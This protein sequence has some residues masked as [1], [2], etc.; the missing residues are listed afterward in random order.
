M[1][2]PHQR[3]LAATRNDV[4]A[5]NDIL[6]E[7]RKGAINSRFLRGPEK[8]RRPAGYSANFGMIPNFDANVSVLVQLPMEVLITICSDLEPIWVFQL[9]LTCTKMA[10]RLR[11]PEANRLWYRCIPAALKALPEFFQDDAALSQRGLVAPFQFNNPPVPLPHGTVVAQSAPWSNGGLDSNINK[12]FNLPAL[13]SIDTTDPLFMYIHQLKGFEQIP[14][15]SYAV[16]QSQHGC[17]IKTLA[18]GIPYQVNFNYRRELL[19]HFLLTR[20]CIACLELPLAAGTQVRPEEVWQDVGG[21]N[22]CPTC[23]SKY[24]VRNDKLISVPG[25]LKHLSQITPQSGKLGPW[26]P[27]RCRPWT[28]QGVHWRPLVDDFTRQKCGLDSEMLLAKQE[29]FDWLRDT[30]RGQ[31]S[32]VYN[33]RQTIRWD[34]IRIAQGYWSKPW[35]DEVPFVPPPNIQDLRNTVIPIHRLADFLFRPEKLDRNALSPQNLEGQWPDDPAD[36][37][38]YQRDIPARTE[39]WK[40]RKAKLMLYQLVMQHRSP[41]MG[42]ALEAYHTSRLRDE[43]TTTAIMARVAAAGHTTALKVYTTKLFLDTNPGFTRGAVLTDGGA[44]A[45]RTA[46]APLAQ[47]SIGCLVGG[48]HARPRGV[49]EVVKHMRVEHAATFFTWNW[50]LA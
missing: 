42:Y 22:M 24:T 41:P 30:L 2:P 18:L 31:T 47:A 40:E 50:L 36:I 3:L 21:M 23:F 45:A 28:G 44:S 49:E 29:Y 39:Q 34:V 7:L 38:R 8:T 11:S 37:I 1:T 15:A 48:C 20:R 27:E 25:L 17:R 5:T 43:L 6:G 16:V 9:E 4:N 35:P 10:R 46:L 12:F 26:L 33:G 14:L 13:R 32:T 19:G